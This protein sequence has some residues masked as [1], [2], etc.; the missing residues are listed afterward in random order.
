MSFP[1]TI[2]PLSPLVGGGTH[3]TKNLLWAYLCAET[4]SGIRTDVASHGYY[5]AKGENEVHESI[6]LEKLKSK[7]N[8]VLSGEVEA[9]K[10]SWANSL[11]RNLRNGDDKTVASMLASVW[12]RLLVETSLKK[13]QLSAYGYV[14]N[15]NN[16]SKST[17]KKE[18]TVLCEWCSK[19]IKVPVGNGF[20]CP[21]CGVYFHDFHPQKTQL[22]HQNEA[23]YEDSCD[24]VGEL[25][26]RIRSG[27]LSLEKTKS[28]LHNAAQISLF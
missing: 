19:E 23:S 9:R 3:Y 18:I 6:A 1:A 20:T 15:G 22:K 28:K 16:R 26:E 4:T 10:N 7:L 11:N 24:E 21:L 25:V 14:M 8:D 27:E 5:L 13:A 2:D 17:Q 12:R